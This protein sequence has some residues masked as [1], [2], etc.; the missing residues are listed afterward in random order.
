MLY[1]RQFNIAE[2]WV[3]DMDGSQHIPEVSLTLFKK[4]EF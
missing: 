1:A 2:E 3:F 4:V